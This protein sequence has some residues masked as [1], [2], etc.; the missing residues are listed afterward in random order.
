MEFIKVLTHPKVYANKSD[1]M[2][3]VSGL[4]IKSVLYVYTM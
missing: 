3:I 2:Q 1:Q 4:S